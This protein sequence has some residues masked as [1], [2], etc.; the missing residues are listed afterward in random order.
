MISFDIIIRNLHCKLM[1]MNPSFDNYCQI[2]IMNWLDQ[3][4]RGSILGPG[5]SGFRGPFSRSDSTVYKFI[6][7]Y[8]ANTLHF[9]FPYSAGKSENILSI[10]ALTNQSYSVKI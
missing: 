5:R 7:Y 9:M 3:A 4:R 6:E 10:R 8:H 1:F 2:T